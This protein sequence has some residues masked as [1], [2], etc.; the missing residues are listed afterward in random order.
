MPTASKNPLLALEACGQAVWFDYI[1]R[2]MIGP[3]LDALIQD[4]GLRGITSNPA[5]FENAI[6]HSDDY[7]AQIEALL[8]RNDLGP[9]A[10]YEELAIEDIQ[11]AADKLLPVYERTKKIDGYVSLEV[12]P[13]L[14]RDTAATVAEARRLWARVARPNLMIKVPGTKE[15]VPAIETL[16]AEGINI[17]VTLLFAQDAYIDVANAFI[18]GLE[19]CAKARK[20]ISHVA[21]VA[22]F[23]ISRIDAAVDTQIDAKIKGGASK[24]IEGLKGKVAIANAKLAHA[25]YQELCASPRWKALAKAGAQPQRLLWASTGT[26]NPAYPDTYY[27]TTLIGN[28]TVNTMSPPVL[29]AFRDH[30]VAK[31]AITDDVDGARK[32]LKDLDAAGISLKDITDKLVVE[33]VRLFADAFDKLLEVVETKRIALEGERQTKLTAT[34][35][36]ELQRAVDAEIEAWRAGGRIRRLWAKDT[37]LWSG[38]DEN[39]WIGWLDIASRE[40]ERAAEYKA[41]TETAKKYEHVLLLGMGGSSLG[42]EVLRETFGRIA[43]HPQLHVLDSTDPAQIRATEAAIDLKKTLFIVSSKSGGTLEPNIF[44]QYFFDRARQVIG[45]QEAAKRFIAVTDPGSNMQK[46]A[47][48]DKFSQI[49]L[50]DSTIGGRYSVLSPFGLVPGAAMGIDIARFLN[51]ALLM[52]RSCGPDVPARVNPG[53]QLGAIFGVAGK[54]GRDKITVLTGPGLEDFGAWTEQLIAESTGKVGEGLIPVDLESVADPAAYGKDRL[55]VHFALTGRPDPQAARIAA[56][57]KSGHPVVRIT[58]AHAYQLG[59]EFFRW[60]LATAVAGSILGIHPFDQPDVEASKI[61]TKKLMDVYEKSGSLPAESPILSD[62][63]VKLYADSANAAALAKA[64][65]DKTLDGYLRAHFARLGAGDYAGFL[66]YI[67]RDAKTIAALQDARHVVRD[68]RKVATVVGFGPRFLHSTGQD[69][70]GGP[71]SGVFLQ[72]TCDD[73]ADL[74]VPDQ[75]YTFGAVKAAQARG[76]FDVLSERGRRALRVHLG[77]SLGPELDK[78]IKAIRRAVAY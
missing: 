8:R 7:D 43:G 35:P 61:A 16:I 14:A 39:K 65:K 12:S 50:G 21:S 70:K 29:A 78:L 26:K 25:K 48:R 77:P 41:L 52:V 19:R 9:M 13:Y 23:F 58:M 17:N 24:S 22:S 66:A 18:S 76:D 38:G 74:P 11:A 68:G 40:V 28:E 42:P 5:I 31:I 60:E 72:I 47:E 32:V 64:A 30:G 49:F 33:A 56:L 20:D 69:Y 54:M 45:P 1:R 71:N 46:V 75:K 53:V 55:F 44:K 27:V 51:A 34:L 62:S 57:E 3:E 67:P 36:D 59:Q 6:G 73:A 4:D 37:G 63:G 2:K 10:L 15:G